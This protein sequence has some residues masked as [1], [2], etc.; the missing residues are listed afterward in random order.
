MNDLNNVNNENQTVAPPI[1]P[2]VSNGVYNPGV[3][4][5]QKPVITKKTYP[6]DNKDFYFFIF[7]SVAS[8]IFIR[9]GVLNAFNLGLTVT[10]SILSLGL[11]IYV[12]SKDSKNKAFY[13]LMFIIDLILAVSF[14][15]HDNSF[16]KFL[17]V[18]V[19]FFTT[20][21]TLNGVSGTHL[22]NDGT[23]LKLADV[24]YVGGIEPLINLNALFSSIKSVFK[25]K[26]N[27]F[28]MAIA[29]VLI[30]VPVLVIV[31][32][33]LSSADVAFNTIVKKVF[34]DVAMLVV[35]LV[36]TV[37]I[38][39]LITSYGFSLSKGITKE[40]NKSFNSKSGK[41]SPVFLNTFLCV[42]ASIYVV[43]LVSQLAY[44]TDTFAFLLPEE[45]SAAQFAR[46][47]FFQMGAIAFINLLITF[48]VSVIEKP[49]D[50][51]KLPV[52]TKLILT[53]FTAFSLFLTV[54]AFI[55]MK[56]YI[57]LYGLTQ[58]RVLTSVFM[59]MLCIIF[60]FVLIRIFNEKFKYI[61]FVIL[62]CALTFVAISVTDIDTYI[63]KY[64]YQKYVEGEIGVDFE[65][66]ETLGNAA[67]P[68]L[69]KLAESD[70]FIIKNLAKESLV[71]IAL[72]EFDYYYD[73]YDS[74]QNE[75][76][77][78][79]SNIFK[80]NR[81]Q[82]IAGREFEK[83]FKSKPG[84]I[85]LDNNFSEYSSK[86]N[87]YGA[88][89][90]MPDF[91]NLDLEFYSPVFNYSENFDTEDK[92]KV[93]EL[94]L[95]YYDD[96]FE[97]AVKSVKERFEFGEKFGYDDEENFVVKSKDFNS[98]TEIAVIEFDMYE[99]TISYMWI[100]NENATEE[101]VK[102]IEIYVSKYSNLNFD[103]WY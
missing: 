28:L 82:E 101:D 14:S 8:F 71:N 15:L 57:D 84:R 93:L 19:L 39:P 86:V 80:Y 96:N 44:I 22:C 72:D 32:P 100:T 36:M 18:I 35:S 26:N 40:K 74:E 79:D 64:N 83:F 65:H 7:V 47:G 61:N 67:V 31:I 43:F 70:D 49:K 12:C 69:I 33:L 97:D 66:Y 21:M 94:T 88:E 11:L 17:T 68:E 4:L 16:I 99:K 20:A 2:P 25:S 73:D 102:D 3:K 1:T 60:L 81:S 24:L 103:G 92:A 55:R 50:N 54:N 56:M 41:V 95:Y 62:T 23:F 10:Y 30:S 34:S 45:F 51:G 29:G 48:L 78:Y 5:P 38:T 90:F 77:E 9:L 89:N 6:I 46:S 27:K 87:E 59:I 37:L 13:S 85:Y 63:S 76:F 98:P 91:N 58:L 42:I 75:E 52:S 53:F